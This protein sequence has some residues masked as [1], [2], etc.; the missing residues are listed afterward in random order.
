MTPE[1]EAKTPLPTFRLAYIARATVPGTFAQ[2][3]AFVEDMYAPKVFGRTE[4]TTTT[5]AAQTQ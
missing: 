4:M 3:A 2:P 1:E 5:I